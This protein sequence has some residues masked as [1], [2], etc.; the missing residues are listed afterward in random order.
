MNSNQF[1]YDDSGHC[2]LAPLHRFV[3][4]FD[5]GGKVGIMCIY[6]DYVLFEHAS[7]TYVTPSGELVEVIVTQGEA[8]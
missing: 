3:P 8:K 1:K 4:V 5:D 6:C 2:D 7:D